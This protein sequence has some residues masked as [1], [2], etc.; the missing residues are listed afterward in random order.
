ME[1]HAKTFHCAHTH[2]HGHQQAWAYIHSKQHGIWIQLSMHSLTIIADYQLFIKWQ[3]KKRLFTLNAR[4]YT[5]NATLWLSY[6]NFVHAQFLL[7]VGFPRRACCF[8]CIDNIVCWEWFS[9]V[10]QLWVEHNVIVNLNIDRYVLNIFSW[11]T[12]SMIE[13]IK[14]QWKQKCFPIH[15]NIR[16]AHW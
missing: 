12:F 3:I 13:R 10:R 5:A 4:I 14:K 15:R 1:I 7:L 11:W 6:V 9:I 8:V 16:C 2:T